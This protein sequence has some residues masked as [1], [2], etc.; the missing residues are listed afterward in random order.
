MKPDR[1]KGKPAPEI[2][3]ARR[4]GA[5]DP[6]P[7]IAHVP[8]PVWVFVM[9]AFLLF[10]GF[11]YL[12]RHGG[13]FNKQVYGPFESTNQLFALRPVGDPD[14]VAGQAVYNKTCLPCHQPS[15]A[16][17]AGQFPPLAGSE[18]VLSEDPSHLI[19]IILNG[20]QGPIEVK[21]QQWN[22]VMVPWKDT[23]KD[24]EIAQVATFVRGAWGNSATKVAPDQVKKI[25]DESAARPAAWTAEDLLKVAPLK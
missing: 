11:V 18:W 25:R 14:L 12:D 1:Q 17:L 5:S 10:W 6:E 13:G 15:G 8:L 20:L 21:G 2:H 7:S 3:P 24:E 19:R 22:A 16:G 23:L 4:S 9:L